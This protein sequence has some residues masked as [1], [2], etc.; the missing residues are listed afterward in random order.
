MNPTQF[1]LSP[2]RYGLPTRE[3][4]RELRVWDGHYHGFNITENEA[5]HREMSLFAERM[6]IE[7]LI[8]LDI[9]G[10]REDPFED[11][12]F[13]RRKLELLVEEKDRLSGICRINPAD[14]EG[15]CRQMEKLIKNGP[16]IGIKFGGPVHN[17]DGILC[18]HPMADPIFK[19]IAE[20]AGVV[21]IHTWMKVGGTVRFPGLGNN[22]GEPT[23]KDVVAVAR[24]Y[25]N[26]PFICGHSGGDW[27]L[28]VREIRPQ[29]NVLLEFSGSDPHSGQVE[30]AIKELGADR[31]TWGG[32]GPS[33]SYS[34]ELGKVFDADISRADR[35]KVLGGNYRRI[36][37]E[38]FRRKGVKIAV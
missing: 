18:S 6:G 33:R 27:E 5:K 1:S 10:A 32:H 16:C 2:G 7:R 28:G 22:R 3:Q 20:L 11:T 31:I 34:T 23:P 26:H 36:S 21:Y 4:I 38:V 35:M 9:G 29:K 14:P 24:R 30:Y 25:P 8:A 19:L 13:A 12:P 17:P 15:S 37:A